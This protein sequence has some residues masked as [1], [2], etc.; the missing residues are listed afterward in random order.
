[1]AK[2]RT[3]DRNAGTRLVGAAASAFLIGGSATGALPFSMTET[4]GFVS[5][6]LAV[7]LLVRESIWTW[8][9][10]IANGVFFLVL[11]ARR[12]IL[13]RQRA[14]DRLHRARPL[15]LVVLAPRRRRARARGRSGGSACRRRRRSPR[16]TAAATYGMLLYLRS[17]DDAAPLAD[18]VTTALSLAATWMQARKQIENWL[19]WLAADA[20]YI[21]LYFVKALPLTGVLYVVFALMCVKGWRDWR[22]TQPAQARAARGG[23]GAVLGKFLP[24]HSGHRHLIETALGQAAEVTVIVVARATEAIPGALRAPLDRGGAPGREVVVLDQDEVGLADDDTAGWARETIRARSAARPTSSSP[25]RTTASRGRRRWAAT[26]SSSTAAGAP[27]RSAATRIRRDPLA[28]LR[29]PERRR[30]RRTTSSASSCSAPRAPARRRSRARSPTTTARSGTR[31]SGTSYSWFRDRPA[32]RLADLDDRR[33]RRDRADCRTGTRTSWPSRR[34]ACSSATRT[35]GRPG[36]STR[37]TSASAR[38]RSTRFADR[39]YDLYDR[40]RPDDAVRAGRARRADATDRTGGDA[41]GV[42][43]AIRTRP[44]RRTSSSPGRT[45]SGCSRRLAERRRCAARTVRSDAAEAAA[46]RE[47]TRALARGRA[48][49]PRVDRAGGGERGPRARRAGRC[50]ERPSAESSGSQTP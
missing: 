23:S 31:S 10:G 33:V 14:P 50:K 34:T 39:D 40:L 18:A 6:A 21:P 43:R 22:R 13:R 30:P 41:R 12:A 16:S 5:G 25:R 20:I 26:T 38:P 47:Q 28:T 3:S 7:W 4:L 49:T 11:F 17:V 1:M 29:V 19:V 46:Q 27:S 45:R 35:P 36:S 42:P 24:F 2:P 48:G 44:A 32:D 37:S 15:G 8:P 9:A